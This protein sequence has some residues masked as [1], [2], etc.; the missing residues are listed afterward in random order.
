[1]KG[2]FEIEK[3]WTTEA[4]HKARVSKIAITC[5][6]FNH[7]CGYVILPEESELIGASTNDSRLND[8]SIH[9]GITFSGN[10]KFTNDP[11]LDN[12]PYAIGFDC[13]HSM[14]TPGDPML[15][16]C[17]LAHGE[18]RSLEYVMAECEDLSKQIK[19][20]EGEKGLYPR[21]Y[22][23]RTVKRPPRFYSSPR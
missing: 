23:C 12:G 6:V 19:E 10:L 21:W 15:R 5:G 4:G 14:D 20:I 22:L 17:K 7:R 1:M 16:V 3:E 9:G 2:L 18:P 11:D 8:I 13:A